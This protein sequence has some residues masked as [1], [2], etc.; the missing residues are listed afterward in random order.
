MKEGSKV[1]KK[2]RKPNKTISHKCDKM[3]ESARDYW[4]VSAP[5]RESLKSPYS[6]SLSPSNDQLVRKLVIIERRK[7]PKSQ[8]IPRSPIGSCIK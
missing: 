5:L 2:L 3:K 4:S 7:F 6:L 1:W 8:A